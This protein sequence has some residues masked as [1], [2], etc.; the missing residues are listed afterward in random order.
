[1]NISEGDECVL[2]FITS[3][4]KLC[5]AK[6]TKKK[7]RATE[8]DN[9]DTDDDDGMDEEGEAE[10]AKEDDSNVDGDDI[11]DD[12]VDDEG[13]GEN[14]KLV[15]DDED[16]EDDDRDIDGDDGDPSFISTCSDKNQYNLVSTYYFKTSI[17]GGPNYF[18][19]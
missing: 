9:D 4:D 14:A 7:P 18:I 11:F 16:D 6:V 17:L 3:E 13:K 12:D 1:N 19:M 15:N 10:D 8:V 5:L 2:K